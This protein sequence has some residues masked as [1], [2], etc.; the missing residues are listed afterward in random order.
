MDRKIFKWSGYEWLTQERWGELHP[1]KPYTYYS[2]DNVIIN[3]YGNLELN[4]KE[5]PKKI[6]GN[7]GK[8]YNP[9]YSMG[10]VS[11][12]GNNPLFKYGEYEWIAKLPKGQNLWPGLWMWSWDRWPPE[13]DVAECWTNNCGG[14][15]RFNHKWRLFQW[16]I[17]SNVYDASAKGN[18]ARC[19][20]ILKGFFKNPS[21]NFIRY[22][23]VW[24]KDRL[25]FYYD[26]SLVRIIDD[27]DFMEYLNANT[28]KG[29]NIIMDLHPTE[30]FNEYKS[31][32]LIIKSFRYDAQ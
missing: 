14:Y 21:E 6:I 25:E 28:K 15:F 32:S 26:G 24:T 11:S 19:I 10:L 31:N 23:L 8:E 13:I 20:P 18:K 27:K 5:N 16:N 9:K 3:A 1:E 12:T 29:M 4:I 30:K 2:K 7:D 17:Q 22:G